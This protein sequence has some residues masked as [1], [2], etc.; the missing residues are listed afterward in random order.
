MLPE[1]DLDTVF[2]R[3]IDSARAI[4]PAAPIDGVLTLLATASAGPGIPLELFAR[5][6]D[7]KDKPGDDILAI[8]DALVALGELVARS[9]P[10]T[11]NEWIGPAHDLIGVFFVSRLSSEQFEQAHWRVAQAARTIQADVSRSRT[12][13]YVKQHLSDHLWLAGRPAE[14]LAAVPRLD[15]P[16]DNL[17]LWQMWEERLAA[18]G[19]NHPNVLG[20]ALTSRHGLDNQVTGEEH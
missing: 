2:T 4:A 7:Q 6:I 5:A 3:A 1:T 20:Y 13:A 8:R 18:L 9:D 17:A 14:A 12:L 19:S 15:T 10:G 16:A 11:A